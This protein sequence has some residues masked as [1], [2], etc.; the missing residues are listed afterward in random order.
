M[1]G[2]PPPG[3]SEPPGS[4][5]PLAQSG[6]RCGRAR[7]ARA[8]APWRAPRIPRARTAAR[9]R[10][11]PAACSVP[12]APSPAEPRTASP[13]GRAG[14]TTMAPPRPPARRAGP[15]RCEPGSTW[16][17]RPRRGRESKRTGGGRRAAALP[18]ARRLDAGPVTA[19]APGRAALPALAPP[20]SA[21]RCSRAGSAPARTPPP[22]TPL[23]S[24]AS[25][26]RRPGACHFQRE[27]GLRA[28]GVPG[29]RGPGGVGPSS[30]TRAL[31][32]AAARTHL[33]AAAPRRVIGCPR[34]ARQIEPSI[35]SW[36]GRARAA[37]TG[38][39][40]ARAPPRSRA[41]PPLNRRR[42]P[43][44]VPGA[45]ERA[46][47]ARPRCPPGGSERGPAAFSPRVCRAP[48]G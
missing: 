11:P 44:R 5:T 48:R 31:R 28:H 6:R 12:S 21:R 30:S 23:T 16:A 38:L 41:R 18:P 37:A 42:P 27:P 26:S 43:R 46:R 22:P 34:P 39:C 33:P 32:P 10:P 25:W 20:G 7:G 13:G 47:A 29:L 45:C 2:R 40:P 9:A 4:P 17:W 14:C 19:A 36:A 8:L 1:K 35:H 3:P 24:T 15:R